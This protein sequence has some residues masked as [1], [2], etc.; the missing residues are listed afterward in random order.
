MNP[1][2]KNSDNFIE[3]LDQ[4]QIPNINLNAFHIINI[5]NDSNESTIDVNDSINENLNCL[6]NIWQYIRKFFK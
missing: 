4:I 2:T 3:N 6:M 5:D 1:C